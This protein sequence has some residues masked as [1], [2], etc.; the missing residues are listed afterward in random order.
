MLPG[1]A[2]HVTATG[3][4]SEAKGGRL[5]NTRLQPVHL[6]TPPDGRDQESTSTSMK[7]VVASSLKCTSLLVVRIAD[8]TLATVPL[9]YLRSS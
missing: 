4:L 8:S 2:R 6:T 9:P 3:F 5:Q 1:D 7:H